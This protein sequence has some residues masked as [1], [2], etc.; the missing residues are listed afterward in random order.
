MVKTIF[1]CG[2]SREIRGAVVVTEVEAE[3]VRLR[4]ALHFGSPVLVARGFRV[5]ARLASGAEALV[6]LADTRAEAIATAKRLF[7]ELPVGAV[8]LR[9]E[10]WS[11][12]VVAGRWVGEP[13]VKGVL[14]KLQRPRRRGRKAENRLEAGQ[15]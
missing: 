9:L 4:T 2:N 7:G 6:C 11:G 10:R 15:G 14:P 3:P 5:I 1:A 13:T 12:G 8:W